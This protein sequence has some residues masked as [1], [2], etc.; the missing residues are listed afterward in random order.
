MEHGGMSQSETDIPHDDASQ[1]V[2]ST[3]VA[4]QDSKDEKLDFQKVRSIDL[5]AS[6]FKQVRQKVKPFSI[7]ARRLYLDAS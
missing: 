6:P 7:N 2:G 1:K 4:E 3:W 5:T